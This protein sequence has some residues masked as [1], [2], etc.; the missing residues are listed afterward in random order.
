MKEMENKFRVS[1]V[2]VSKETKKVEKIYAVNSKGEPFD[3][4]EIG[5]LEHFKIITKDQIG[6]KLKQHQIKGTLITNGN[7][8]LLSLHSKEDADLYIEH[9]GQYFNDVLL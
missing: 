6:E 5:I 2:L 7:R 8:T 1:Q 3:L 9:I 4:L